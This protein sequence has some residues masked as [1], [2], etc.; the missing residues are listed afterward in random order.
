M[1]DRWWYEEGGGIGWG[2]GW[3]VVVWVEWVMCGGTVWVVVLEWNCI[4][5]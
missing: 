2:V 1:G 4:V 5:Y 3:L